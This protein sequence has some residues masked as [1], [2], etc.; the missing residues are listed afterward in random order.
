MKLTVDLPIQCLDQDTGCIQVR[1]GPSL[2]NI[3]D[4]IK[5]RI[6]LE[7][8]HYLDIWSVDQIT[9]RKRFMNMDGWCPALRDGMED[10]EAGDVRAKQIEGNRLASLFS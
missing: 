10:N 4:R 8:L 1:M 5:I 3:P 6:R 7:F 9:I 2:N